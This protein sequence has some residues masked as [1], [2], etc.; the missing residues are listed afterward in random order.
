MAHPV[1]LARSAL[2]A[3]RL[4]ARIPASP[5]ATSVARRV[6]FARPGQLAPPRGIGHRSGAAASRSSG[7]PSEGAFIVAIGSEDT[8][9]RGSGRRVLQAATRMPV[10]VDEDHLTPRRL[11]RRPPMC[12]SR[13]AAAP[14]PPTAHNRSAERPRLRLPPLLRPARHLVTYPSCLRVA[15]PSRL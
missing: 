15:Y 1:L 11:L 14:L 8:A 12:G 2:L 6:V 5:Q 4:A 10:R 7:G 3:A 9:A 13:L